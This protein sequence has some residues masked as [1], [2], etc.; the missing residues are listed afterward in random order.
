MAIRSCRDIA[1][2]LKG[3][4]FR[5]IAYDGRTRM[6]REIPTL[7]RLERRRTGGAGLPRRAS[8]GDGRAHGPSATWTR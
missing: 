8:C 5:R 3:S 2:S 6:L 7:G 4:A 1:T